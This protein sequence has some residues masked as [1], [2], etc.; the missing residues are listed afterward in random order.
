MST[1]TDGSPLRNTTVRELRDQLNAVPEEHLDLE[2]TAHL[3]LEESTKRRK[4]HNLDDWLWANSEGVPAVDLELTQ[5]P[6]TVEDPQ[7]RPVA[8]VVYCY[9]GSSTAM[10]VEVQRA[11]GEFRERRDR[12]EL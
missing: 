6:S 9:E 7:P 3:F 1:R 11:F 4:G 2:V 8:Y 10:S 12:G 5:F